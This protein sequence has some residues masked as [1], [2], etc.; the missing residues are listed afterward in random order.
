MTHIENE[1]VL[2]QML[3]AHRNKSGIIKPNLVTKIIKEFLCL[4]ISRL[5]ESPA[6][7]TKKNLNELFSMNQL[8]DSH[9]TGKQ[10]PL[11]EHLKEIDPD[12]LFEQIPDQILISDWILLFFKILYFSD[13]ALRLP[14]IAKHFNPILTIDAPVEAF[15]NFMFLNY[16]AFFEAC[17]NTKVPHLKTGT[18]VL[19]EKYIRNDAITL[20][21]ISF[22]FIK[23]FYFPNT[24][25]RFLR[26]SLKNI[27]NS[28]SKRFPVGNK[29]NHPQQS[30]TISETLRTWNKPG[31]YCFFTSAILNVIRMQQKMYNSNGFLSLAVFSYRS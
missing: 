5:M 24:I 9:N 19:C 27:E 22:C 26:C 21:G 23:N 28:L 1:S 17:V 11:P 14:L 10:F 30:D 31:K 29:R 16:Q 4:P 7:K 8:L 20:D 12:E 3:D 18:P 13:T 15:D 6:W 2:S 25:K